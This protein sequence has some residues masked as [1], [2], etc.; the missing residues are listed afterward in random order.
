MADPQPQPNPDDKAPADSESTP[1]EQGTESEEQASPTRRAVMRLLR[2]AVLL[3]GGLFLFGWLGSESMIFLPHPP[4]YKDD[5]ST[6]KLKT[7]SGVTITAHRYGPEDAAWT[8]LFSHGNA[9]DLGDLRRIFKR[10]GAAGFQ[11]LAYDYP[12]YGTSEG[13][14]TEQGCYEAIDAAWTHAVEVL[15]VAPEQLI[16]YGRSVG[17][18]PSTYLATRRPH[19]GLILQAPFTSCFKVALPITVLP[20]DRFPNAARIQHYEG[21][22]LLLHGERDRVVPVHH[23][24][25]VFRLARGPKRSVFHEHAGHNNLIAR[26]GRQWIAE[27]QTFAKSLEGRGAVTPKG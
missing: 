24:R 11:V 20:F 3:W 16:I 10:L 17:S 6:I 14:P 23:G 19:A 15:K 1:S 12:G 2:F 26:L 9:E 27:L 22:L 13:T 18:G 5:P 8:I 7:A 21:P 4:G 25:E